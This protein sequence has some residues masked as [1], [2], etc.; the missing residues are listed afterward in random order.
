MSCSFYSWVAHFYSWVVWSDSV[1]LSYSGLLGVTHRLFI[2][3]MSCSRVARSDSLNLSNTRFLAHLFGLAWLNKAD[4]LPFGSWSLDCPHRACSKM[5]HVCILEK[6]VAFVSPWFCSCFC[7]TAVSDTPDVGLCFHR[8]IVSSWLSSCPSVGRRGSFLLSFHPLALVGLSP[9]VSLI[10][11]GCRVGSVFATVTTQGVSTVYVGIVTSWG[12]VMIVSPA[13]FCSLTF[14][15]VLS[16]HLFFCS[17]TLSGFL[18]RPRLSCSRLFPF[19]ILT[20]RFN[21][22]ISWISAASV[23]SMSCGYTLW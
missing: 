7:D 23:A 3:L 14:C 18:V 6:E 8:C 13:F 20:C 12:C 17:L 4:F 1:N 11:L 15:R 10:W 16:F 19:W 5:D 2:L 21:L 22:S 9:S